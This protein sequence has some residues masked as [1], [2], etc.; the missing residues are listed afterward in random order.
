MQARRPTWWRDSTYT[1]YLRRVPNHKWY[2]P[3]LTLLLFIIL[4]LG[5]TV[6]LIVALGILLIASGQAANIMQLVSSSLPNAL[7]ASESSSGIDAS[8]LMWISIV[9]QYG[10]VAIMLPAI[11][12]ARRV[13]EKEPV[14]T[15]S[16]LY[17][18]LRWN[19][20]GK[21]CIVSF[22]LIFAFF[23][24]DAALNGGARFTTPNFAAL[25]CV[26]TIIPV[27]CAAEEY[28]FR[29]FLMQT[30]GRWLSPKLTLL[31]PILPA[32]IFTSMHSYDFWGL[33][34]IFGFGMVCGYLVIF[35]GGLEAGIAYHIANNTLLG[36]MTAFDPLAAGSGSSVTSME[37]VCM[38]YAMHISYFV[39]IVIVG[40]K[41]HWFD[42]VPAPISIPLP[43]PVPI[44]ASTLA[45]MRNM[46]AKVPPSRSIYNYGYQER[47]HEGVWRQT[48]Q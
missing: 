20:L 10:G 15:L 25:I 43:T 14:S 46:Y 22:G 31:V 21:C 40:N 18:G 32:L 33:T 39:I 36:L 47:A 2:K 23:S 30:M 6:L 37:T 1:S 13:V 34:T 28:V 26:L 17:G 9:V 48:P 35:T 29:G 5:F 41:L 8:S 27:Q 11:L 42:A 38:E 45:P 16:S 12:I 4:Y 19:V 3:I 44:S 24:L 7:D